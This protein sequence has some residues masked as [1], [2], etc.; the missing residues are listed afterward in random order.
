VETAVVENPTRRQASA[1]NSM[2][3]ARA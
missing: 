2:E 1:A 3:T